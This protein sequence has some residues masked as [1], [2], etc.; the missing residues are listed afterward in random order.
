[1]TDFIAGER[2]ARAT[3]RYEK[4][5]DSAQK[6]TAIRAALLPS[7]VAILDVTV[8]KGRSLDALATATNQPRA[9]LERL[10]LQA[11]EKLADHFDSARPPPA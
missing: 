10:Y 9:N 1:M 6:V 3:N 2:L 5:V 11:S 7:E 4:L 8:L